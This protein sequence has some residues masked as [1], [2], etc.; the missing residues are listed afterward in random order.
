M[1]IN[2]IEFG[3][4]PSDCFTINKTELAARLKK[5][6]I[7]NEYDE[8]IAKFNSYAKYRFAY[9]R[10]PVSVVKDKC[11]FDCGSVVS[12]SLSTILSDCSEA[13]IFAVSSGIEAD[14]LL[15]RES[16][17]SNAEGFILDAI[18][19]AMIESFADYVNIL[20]VGDQ[21]AT[22]RFSPGYADFPL[23][24]QRTL[25]KRLNAE[26][27]VGIALSEQLLMTPMKSITA[28]IGIY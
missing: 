8:L 15:S 21:K 12:S 24:F 4:V 17:K 20:I 3:V 25:L 18:G 11:V 16:I 10:V 27:T 26:R 13:V 22:K 1:L 19:S 23:E 7:N 9:T 5:A 6:D 14:K 2:D 28:V